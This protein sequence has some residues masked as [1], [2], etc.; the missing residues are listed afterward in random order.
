MDSGFQLPDSRSFSVELGFRIRIVSGIPDS[1]TCIPDS[2]AQDSGFHKQKFPRFRIPNAII[3]R[4]PEYGFLYMGRLKGRI[5]ETARANSLTPKPNPFT[6]LIHALG[7]GTSEINAPLLT[8]LIID[9]CNNGFCAANSA[10]V[11]PLTPQASNETPKKSHAEFPRLSM[12]VFRYSALYQI[13]RKF[14]SFAFLE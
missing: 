14:S 2:K 5:N 7:W 3:S 12:F 13:D 6:S 9:K 11:S 8:I 1:Y 10:V 4:I